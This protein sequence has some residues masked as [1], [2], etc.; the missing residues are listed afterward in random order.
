MSSDFCAPFLPYNDIKQIADTFLNKYH[1]KRNYPTPIERIIEL[2]FKISII[3]IP[4]LLKVFEIDGWLSYSTKEIYVDKF[5]Y[6]TRPPRFNFTL[7]Y[8][9]GHYIL[10]KDIYKTV[11]IDS[12]A[13]WRK[14]IKSFPERQLAWFEWQARAFA[15]IVLVPSDLLTKRTNYYLGKIKKS[16]VTNNRIIIDRLL[17]VL[18]KDFEVSKPVIK[19]RF[20]KEQILPNGLQEELT[21]S[22]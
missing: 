19:K 2:Q 20:E 16:G 15:G 22:F 4:G 10:H 21:L 18:A 14:L 17:D 8:E 11:E 3:G 12:A 7:A 5:M 9:I 13:E 6:D 1:P